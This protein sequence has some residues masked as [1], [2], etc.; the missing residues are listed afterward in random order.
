MLITN[1]KNKDKINTPE[2]LAPAG[3][4]QQLKAALA[5]G[6]DAV[7]MGGTA[8]NARINA[9]NFKDGELRDAI[10]TAHEYGAGVNIT[11]NTLVKDSEIPDALAF[12]EKV[13]EYGADALIVQDLGLASLIR[14][15]L[16]DISLHL[17]TQGTVYDL[18]GVKAA[19][20]AGF[21]RVVLS[22]ELS[23]REIEYICRNSDIEIETFVHGAICICYSGQCHMSGF[24]GGRSGNRGEC[25]QPC[26]LPYRL[27]KR[28]SPAESGG[29]RRFLLSAS[30]MCSLGM[31]K[32][33]INAGVSSF[34]IEGRMK[35]P[36]YVA[37]T[38][39]IYRKY[40][41]SIRSGREIDRNSLQADIKELRQIYSRGGFTD[42]YLRGYSD[43]RLMSEKTQ[44]HSGI[45]AGVLLKYDRKKRLAVVKLSEK[46][47]N[48][49]GIEIRDGRAAVG[50]I[51]TYI[52]DNS[53]GKQVKSLEAGKTGTIGD[54]PLRQGS[55]PPS[56]GAPLYKLS[57]KKQME[58][59]ADSY[60]II[61]P[62]VEVDMRFE[63]K[64]NSRAV[65]RVKPCGAYGRGT[66]EEAGESETRNIIQ[67]EA[68]SEGILEAAASRPADRDYILRFL[69]KTGG[70][71]YKLRKLRADI[72]DNIF[73]PASELNNMR[74][75]A[76]D[77]LSRL[78]RALNRRGADRRHKEGQKEGENAGFPAEGQKHKSPESALK[79]N[80]TLSLY[81]FNTIGSDISGRIRDTAEKMRKTADA[82]LGS[83][84][85][86]L[87]YIPYELFIPPSKLMTHLLALK[88]ASGNIELVPYLPVITRGLGS[89]YMDE[90]AG[91]I[92]R[93][94]SD[95]A[96]SALLISNISHYKLVEGKGIP[97]ITDTG[98]NI[99]NA[100]AVEFWR[101]R[102]AIMSA[103]SE[104][105]K[106]EDLRGFAGLTEACEVTVYGRI[107]VMHTEHCPISGGG[108]RCGRC[109]SGRYSLTDRKNAEFP[110]L[111]DDSFCRA[112]ILSCRPI[113]RLNEV[114]KMSENGIKHFRV[115][116]FEE[117]EEP[118]DY[119]TWRQDNLQDEDVKTLSKKA[120]DFLRSDI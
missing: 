25:A 8:F 106:A 91:N 74:R 65:L 109:G 21:S 71:P 38:T 118:F 78:R 4:K 9:D 23:L 107:A 1:N 57:D 110:V 82:L 35:S 41:D 75:T 108:E 103:L 62:R 47:S 111:T 19:A 85:V 11:L 12:T 96:I 28:G 97:F 45:E 42:A 16:P 7:Y 69:S 20:D 93:L 79:D 44:K 29:E 49:D 117:D 100:P 46:L 104:E 81:F 101:S 52:L 24:I 10:N 17:S 55:A 22:R 119:T 83:P 87:L 105:P 64:V 90:I 53:S 56:A 113:N 2:L 37:I 50:N 27:K 98:M 76:L 15:E 18:N 102:G 14:R 72:G 120:M 115:N 34:K 6:A 112:E 32:E 51:V 67:A 92:K 94:Y 70:T 40:I 3:G 60:K 13:Y 59:A 43:M 84:A 80:P 26:R 116:V 89:E 95:G 61:P 63:G 5:C 58:R 88:K 99:F 36:E 48:G 77:E 66:R 68:F 73:I 30:D 86:L 54:I 114:R 39:G 33:L 31:I